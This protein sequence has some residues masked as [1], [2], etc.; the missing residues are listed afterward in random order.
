MIRRAL[1]TVFTASV[2]AG[3]GTGMPG[4]SQPFEMPQFTLAPGWTAEPAATLDYPR[5]SAL[6]ARKAGG[7]ALAYDTQ[8]LGGKDVFV[9]LSQDGKTWTSPVVVGKTGRTEES[10]ALW[11]DAQGKL[12][13]VYASNDS[14]SFQLYASSSR[15]GK[16]WAEPVAITD[17][18]EHAKAPSVTRTPG[19]GVA[20]AYQT[21]GGACEV[22]QSSDGEVWGLSRRIETSGGDPAICHDGEG[23]RV[24][25]HRNEKLYER[26]E[27]KG[28]WS[29]AVQIPGAAAMREPAIAAIAGK[30]TLAYSTLSSNGAWKLALR[31]AGPSGWGQEQ[32][33]V[34][35][36]D[37]HGY[38]SLAEGTE[39]G[40]WLAWGISRLT[41]ERGIFV[42]RSGGR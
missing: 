22:M 23:L 18:I 13:L 26:V 19:G 7:F 12:H 40:S 37:D 15:D 42:A 36:P 11:E 29:E 41:E 27:R 30:V 16:A 2:L 1:L 21:L 17:E 20:I 14:G 33:L 4:M 10:P 32:D 9:T 39:G 24:V 25:F 6:L 38:P 8:K 35:G 31:E 5:V 3:C 34:Q 28:V